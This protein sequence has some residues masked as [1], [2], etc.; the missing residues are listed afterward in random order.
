[1]RLPPARLRDDGNAEG[2]RTLLSGG[3]QLVAMT[4]QRRAAA[5]LFPLSLI[6][7]AG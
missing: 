5:R 7:A 1:M 6:S 4:A 2:D 3:L